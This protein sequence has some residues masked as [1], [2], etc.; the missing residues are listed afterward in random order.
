[1]NVYVISLDKPGVSLHIGTAMQSRPF[2]SHTGKEIP[3][4]H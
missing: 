3:F 2:P 4:T 1:M